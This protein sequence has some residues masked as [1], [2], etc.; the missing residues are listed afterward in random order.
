[1]TKQKSQSSKGYYHDPRVPE[2]PTY[3][4]Q[5]ETYNYTPYHPTSTKSN[6]NT[7]QKDKRYT[8][9]KPKPQQIPA[10]PNTSQPKK[11]NNTPIYQQKPAAQPAIPK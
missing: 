11:P 1:M 3:I 7:T 2:T 10:K 5:Q 6:T 4:S 9:Q 8:A